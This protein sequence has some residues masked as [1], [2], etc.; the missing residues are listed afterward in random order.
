MVDNNDGRAPPSPLLV[1]IKQ[2][3]EE[4]ANI[5]M[6]MHE[7]AAKKKEMEAEKEEIKVV[8]EE[9]NKIIAQLHYKL[10]Q[11]SS[12][13]A[14]DTTKS[15]PQH[16]AKSAN[17]GVTKSKSEIIDEYMELTKTQ[18]LPQMRN[19]KLEKVVNNLKAYIKENH[20]AE[21]SLTESE[22]EEHYKNFLEDLQK[23]KIKTT[24]YFDDKLRKKVTETLE[25]RAKKAGFESV[26]DL[27]R[28]ISRG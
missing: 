6:E 7:L 4:R 19:E 20:G 24:P 18:L 23:Q 13:Y 17:A 14:N 22:K 26:E 9:Q 5:K 15:P 12:D 11:N 10:N 25:Y 1:R 16:P 28:A 2:L 21:L 27:Y 8:M 3:E